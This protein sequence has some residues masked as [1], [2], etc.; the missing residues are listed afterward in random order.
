MSHSELKVQVPAGAVS[1]VRGGDGPP[2]VYMHSAVGDTWWSPWCDALDRTVVIPAHPGFAGSEGYAS[3]DDMDDL[4][5]HYDEVFD[6]LGLERFALMGQSLGG[7]IA[8]EYAV[9]WPRR[10]E[11]LILVDAAGL[12]VKDA[13]VPDMWRMRPPEL[14]DVL[15]ADPDQPIAMMLRSFDRSNP[16]GEDVLLPFIQAQQTTARLAW[17]P[18]L[19]HPKLRGRLR[20]VSCPTLVVWGAEDRFI[21]LE[22]GRAYQELI[23]GAELTTIEGAGHL[24]LIERP[25]ATAEAI[26]RF[27]G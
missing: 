26:R 17:N 9:R 14:A 10:L 11:A 16:P 21:P 6:A 12:R 15:F 7:W 2:L 20:R 24:P 25:E 22:H 1:V 8:A 18:Y 27:L 13:P 5:F 3:I 23:D 4:V 19:H